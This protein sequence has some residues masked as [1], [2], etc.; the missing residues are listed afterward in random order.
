MTRS[1][2]KGSTQAPI[3]GKN[4]R[5]SYVNVTWSLYFT[6]ETLEQH[7]NQKKRVNNRKA[8]SFSKVA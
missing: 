6:Y 5:K 1:I 8:Q 2:L 3:Q 4:R 7:K